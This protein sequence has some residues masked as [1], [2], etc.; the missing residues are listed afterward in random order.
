MNIGEF[1]QLTGLSIKALRR[2]D[3]QGLLRPAVVDPWSRYRRYSAPQLD[4]AVRLKALRAAGVGLAEAERA[5]TGPAAAA[6]V[7]SEHREAVQAE[8][9]RQEQALEAAEVLLRSGAQDFD[10]Q[11][12]QA[13]ARH[14]VG[15]V[16]TE[17]GEPDDEDAATEHANEAFAALWRALAAEG[18]A[19]TGA[20]WTSMRV[21][22]Q[23]PDAVELLCCRPVARPL[24]DNW[25]LPGHR[26][27][28]GQLPAGP[29]LVVGWRH[30]DPVPAI[31]GANHPAVLALLVQAEARGV[32]LDV[33]R[34]R[35]GGLLEDGENVGVEV[36]IPLAA[37][38]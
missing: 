12:R 15:V 2:Y 29:E 33:T 16:L 9:R 22:P 7:L 10:V 4:T 31:D 11:Q 17:T 24:P 21:S 3:E 25:S 18:N 37:Q 19:P 5:L 6:E 26:V 14:W 8:R 1:A 36:C 13:P 28:T 23:E 27:E 32:D 35:Q 20:F 34:L 38:L 30:D